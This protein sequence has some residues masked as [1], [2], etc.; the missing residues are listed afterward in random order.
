MATLQKEAEL[1]E[2]VQLVG[3]DALPEKEKA[4]LDVA[5]MI[6][7]DFLQQSAFDEVDS[8]CSPM[9]QYGML[10]TIME[11][12][13][14]QNEALERGATMEQLSTLPVRE[15]ISRMKEV[16]EEQV[17]AFFA[18]LLKEIAGQMQSAGTQ[19]AGA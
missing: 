9:K 19:M 14:F 18:D 7:E 16:K 13:R 4:V 5:R 6:R 1:Q 15:R 11:M 10:R 2:V 8:Y 12:G 3:Y 17:E